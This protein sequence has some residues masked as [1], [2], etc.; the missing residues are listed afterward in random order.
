[1]KKAERKPHRQTWVKV[2]APVDE[3]IAELVATLSQIEG[4]ETL[5]SCQGWVNGGE[6]YVYFYYGN[7]KT[8]TRLAFENIAPV[9]QGINGVSVSVEVFNQ[10]DPMGK[11][12]I[13]TEVIPAVTSALVSVLN[14]D[15]TAYSC[16]RV[17][18]RPRNC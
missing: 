10:S 3:G 5:A 9:L 4:L 8:I 18:T 14:P 11:L 15:K 2:N 16:N 1:M 6:A 7:W 13:R 12:G 17:C